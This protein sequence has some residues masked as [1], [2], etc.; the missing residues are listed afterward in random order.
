LIQL[1][2]V[3]NL[4]GSQAPGH[5]EDRDQLSR[6]TRTADDGPTPRERRP[7]RRVTGARTD[8][9]DQSHSR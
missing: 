4:S 8:S 5:L 2:V 6:F 9:A 1:A 3:V 7:S